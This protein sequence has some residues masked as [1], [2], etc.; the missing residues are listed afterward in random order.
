ME[1]ATELGAETEEHPHV[2]EEQSPP[3]P[4]RTLDIPSGFEGS[5][6]ASDANEAVLVSPVIDDF[7]DVTP[8]W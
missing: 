2:V 1:Y 7:P 6:A 4:L 3:L 5:L 8:L